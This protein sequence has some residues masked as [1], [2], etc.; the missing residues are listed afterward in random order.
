MRQNNH[1]IKFTDKG[2]SHR[3]S[4]SLFFSFLAFAWLIYAI[5]SAFYLGDACGRY[6]GGIGTLA[7]LFEFFALLLALRS[8]K[9]QKVFPGI[10]RAAVAFALILLL[11][12]AAVYG[13]GVYELWF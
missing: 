9:D 12:W 3:G 2:N 6:V 7:L 8:L 4:W 1:K 5:A 13:L 10:P 11:L